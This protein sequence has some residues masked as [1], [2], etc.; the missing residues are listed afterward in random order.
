MRVE[1][2]KMNEISINMSY[3]PYCG[4][5]I[6]PSDLRDNKCSNCGAY[7]DIEPTTPPPVI[8]PKVSRIGVSIIAIITII[9]GF[10]F[11][12]LGSFVFVAGVILKET[13]FVLFSFWVLILGI[14]FIGFGA[15]LRSLRSWVWWLTIIFEVFGFISTLIL[16]FMD[17]FFFIFTI[18][19][20]V[21]FVGLLMVKKH[22]H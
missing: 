15:G 1:V 8:V 3:C 12:W 18:P 6:A 11:L 9:E 5:K 22:F 19:P 2:Y 13:G 17:E 14:I 7:L 20:I 4:K 16:G 10:V 21:I